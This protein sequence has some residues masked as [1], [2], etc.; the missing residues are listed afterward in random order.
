MTR[1]LQKCHNTQLS[2]INMRPQGSD[3]INAPRLP[4]C[5]ASGVRTT[6][7]GGRESWGRLRG[8]FAARSIMGI[9]RTRSLLYR[10][11]DALGGSFN[12]FSH[13]LVIVLTDDIAA[14]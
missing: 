14:S 12:Q 10:D 2:E 11:S 3:A 9:T 6:G 4:A 1:P 7:G 5:P 8:C 13:V